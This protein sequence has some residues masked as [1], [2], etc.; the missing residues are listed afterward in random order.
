[1]EAMTSHRPYRPALGIDKAIYEITV[2]SGRLYPADV[3]DACRMVLLDDR[4]QF[5][6]EEYMVHFV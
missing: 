2:N 1:V 5:E 4:Y 6:D 3:V